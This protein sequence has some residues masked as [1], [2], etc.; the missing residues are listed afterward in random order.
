MKLIVPSL[1]LIGLFCG[2]AQDGSSSDI[3]QKAK[4]AIQAK[5][6]QTFVKEGDNQNIQI[7]LPKGK[8]DSGGTNCFDVTTGS[9][10]AILAMQFTISWDKN[11]LAFS[12]VKN[13]K[14]PNLGKD[15]FGTTFANEGKLTYLWIEDALQGVNLQDG[16]ALFQICFQGI[17]KKGQSTDLILNG[18]PTPVEIVGVGD[19]VLGVQTNKGNITIQ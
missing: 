13:F 6:E 2:C 5:S 18:N 8:I 15:N 17:G 19:K 11:I 3:R 14:L 10:K 9:F 16:T 7:S 1:I 4:D 12:E